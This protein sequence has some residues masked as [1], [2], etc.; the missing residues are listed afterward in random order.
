MRPETSDY[1]FYPSGYNL[2]DNNYIVAVRETSEFPNVIPLFYVN[3][4]TDVM[5]ID[6]EEVGQSIFASTPASYRQTS[7][8][9]V[10]FEFNEL[11]KIARGNLQERDGAKSHEPKRW[12]LSKDL[13]DFQNNEIIE[14]LNGVIDISDS[15]IEL[16]NSKLATLIQKKYLNSNKL[17]FVGDATHSIGP[18]VFLNV[19]Q[20]NKFKVSKINKF[21]FG[22]YK[23]NSV[24]KI[25]F[26]SNGID[27][28]VIFQESIEKSFIEK[29]DFISDDELIRW[30]ENEMIPESVENLDFLNSLNS[31][32]NF[33]LDLNHND[34]NVERL[35]RLEKL[36]NKS[37]DILFSK[38]ALVKLIPELKSVKEEISASQKIRLELQN[39]ITSK[40]KEKELILLETTNLTNLKLELEK[41][42]IDLKNSETEFKENQIL[43][44]QNVIDELEKKRYNLEETIEQEYGEKSKKVSKL[45]EDVSY[46]E[47]RQDEL[48]SSI[49]ILKKEFISAQKESHEKLRELVKFNTQLSFL[50]GRDL[51][52]NKDVESNTDYSIGYN[53]C[54]DYN[55]L[56]EQIISSFKSHDR[57]YASHFIDNILI[58]IHQNTL[59]FFA[60]LPGTG[61]TSLARLLTSFMSP[62]KRVIE[63]PVSRGWTSQKDLIGFKNPLNNKFQQS[64]TGL[65]SLLKQLDFEN[66]NNSTLSSPMSYVILDEANLSPIEHYWSLFN[67]TTDKISNYDSPIQ[68]NLGMDT[69]FTYGNNIR[70]IGTI[71]YDQTTE[72]LSPRI[73][74]RANI[75]T[76]FNDNLISSNKLVSQKVENINIDFKTLI[77]IFSLPDYSLSN[78]DYIIS[79]TIESKYNSVKKLFSD[80]LKISISPRVEIAIRQYISVASKFM[81]EELRPLDYC[82][83]QRLLPMINIQADKRKELEQL[84]EILLSFKLD[85]SIS[86]LILR[87]IIDAGNRNDYSQDN[88]NYFLALSHA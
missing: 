45:Q 71:N 17:F 55:S 42:I 63:I 79:E 52:Q 1:K 20:N 19:L 26:N 65:Y 66:S 56:K 29:Y 78:A 36:L 68:I 18:F 32:R 8:I 3:E 24:D 80:N 60:G 67:V 43:E 85:D 53:T 9:D 2:D 54:K 12:I 49:E 41:D 82:I 14:V 74:D 83:A 76:L 87:R 61:K 88:Y 11:I 50:S 37:Q 6:F 70:F 13:E 84:L 33:I 77:D 35:K 22:K 46:Y 28:I 38:S 81:I 51:T 10:R 4:N 73:I 23:F 44:I 47:K 48:K 39:S 69:N 30:F 7:G 25:E 34:E 5:S 31:L 21:N 59:T 75:I 62:Q 40:E 58:S 86:C 72:D 27:R 57:N 16:K 64:S 15:I